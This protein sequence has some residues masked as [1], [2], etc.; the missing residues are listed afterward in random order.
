MSNQTNKIPMTQEGYEE[1]QKELRYYIDTVRPKVIVELQEARAQGDLSEN[2]D[3]DAA[4]DQQAFVEAKIKEL[5]N[6]IANAEIIEE[7]KEGYKT[8]RLGAT[9]TILDVEMDEEETFRI[10]GSPEADPDNGKL[11]NVSPLAQAILEKKVGDVVSVKV[12]S[13]Y[14][15]EI[16]NI[17]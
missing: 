16:L 7:S 15:V 2:A 12:K 14:E 3:Y 10:V 5:N 4:R 9:V 17:K 8:V 6:I 11:S 1:H 13:P